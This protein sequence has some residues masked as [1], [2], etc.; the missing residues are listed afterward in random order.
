VIASDNNWGNRRVKNDE[1]D[2]WGLMR[3][4]PYLAALEILFVVSGT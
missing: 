1:R 3:K 4:C 2:G